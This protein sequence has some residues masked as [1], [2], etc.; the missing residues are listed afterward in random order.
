MIELLY[1]V[2]TYYLS[3]ISHQLSYHNNSPQL[4][5]Y[6]LANRLGDIISIG[7]KANRFPHSEC[8]IKLH[9]SF[10]IVQDLKRNHFKITDKKGTLIVITLSLWH[11]L[12]LIHLSSLCSNTSCPAVKAS[13]TPLQWSLCSCVTRMPHTVLRS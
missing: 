1:L 11:F 7:N 3:L 5:Y 4:R 6:L 10:G 8:F 2:Q 9:G 13:G 12:Y